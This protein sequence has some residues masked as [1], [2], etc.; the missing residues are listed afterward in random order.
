M[1]AAMR[2][3]AGGDGI[4]PE[5]RLQ[6]IIRAPA[7]QPETPKWSRPHDSAPRLQRVPAPH[8]FAR[9][10][11][12]PSSGFRRPAWNQPPASAPAYSIFAPRR[13]LPATPYK[14]AG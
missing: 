9:W 13:W 4:G 14:R 11:Q 8:L 5:Q 6:L 10:T 2:P 12:H 3:L 1:T 7:L